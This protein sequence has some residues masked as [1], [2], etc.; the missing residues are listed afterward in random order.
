MDN[1]NDNANAVEG[2][3]PPTERSHR[4][5]RKQPHR[6][7]RIAGQIRDRRCQEGGKKRKGEKQGLEAKQRGGIMVETINSYYV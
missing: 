3:V 4:G 6:K 1:A 5:R 7:G 2:S